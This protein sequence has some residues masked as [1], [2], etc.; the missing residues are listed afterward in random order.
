M[1]TVKPSVDSAGV[2][3]P[4]MDAGHQ[5]GAGGVLRDV[6]VRGSSGVTGEGRQITD[7]DCIHI[8]VYMYIYMCKGIHVCM[9]IYIYICVCVCVCL[10]LYIYVCIYT[11]VHL[12]M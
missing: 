12:S 8:Y 7:D 4:R 2:Q 6:Q 5:Q 11:Y 3:S 1:Q 9:H 10:Y